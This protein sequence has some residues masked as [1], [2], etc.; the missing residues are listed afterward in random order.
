MSRKRLG[1]QYRSVG[2]NA[3]LPKERDDR[4]LGLSVIDPAEVLR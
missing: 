4:M 2:A 1:N 3:I